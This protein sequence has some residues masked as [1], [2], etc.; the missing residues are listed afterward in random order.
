MNT[1]Q[2][3]PR[4][5]LID[6]GFAGLLHSHA[7]LLDMHLQLWSPESALIFSELPAVAPALVPRVRALARKAVQGGRAMREELPGGRL[8]L[9]VPVRSGGEIVGSIAALPRRAPGRDAKAGSC[10]SASP[11]EPSMDQ[12]PGAPN[13]PTTLVRRFTLG[14]EPAQAL[15]EALAGTLG[16]HLEMMRRAAD[17]AEELSSLRSELGLLHRISARLTEPGNAHQTIEFILRHGCTAACA[18]LAMLQL[19]DARAPVVSRNPFIEASRIRTPGKA[20]RQLAG[21]LWQGMRDWTGPGI[22]GCLD[23]ILGERS[24]LPGPVQI[25][26]SRISPESAKTGFLAFLRAGLSPFGRHELRLLDSLAEQAALGLRAV[27][28]HEN[29]NDFLMSTVKAL[30]SAIETKDAYTSGHSARVNLI[31]M[32]LGKQ[33]DLPPRQLEA[34]KWASILHDVGKIGMPEAILNKPGR[35]DVQEF[36]IVKQHPWRGY[37]VL[38][39]ISQLKAASQAVLFHHER[40]DGRGYPLGISGDAIPLPARIIAVADTFDA[41]TS[42]RPYREAWTEDETHAEILRVRNSQLD[43]Q[44]VDALGKMIS[45]LK[46]HRIM[47]QSSRQEAA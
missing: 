5:N 31:S 27:D 29:V 11:G 21:L 6:S 20:L 12:G 39:H 43:P 14:S 37:E 33:L 7:Q 36:E 2:L 8:L 32:L 25:A 17:Q 45:F 18:D 10:A 41:L 47:L 40:L 19:P 22:H 44:V 1:E 16:R 28:L 38:S 42:T 23:E 9:A 24:P 15:I 26:I 35:L 30:V 13:G 3:S 46:E 4:R 34:L